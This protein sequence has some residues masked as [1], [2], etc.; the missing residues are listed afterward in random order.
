M[1]NIDYHPQIIIIIHKFYP[2]NFTELFFNYIFTQSFLT[3]PVTRLPTTSITTGAMRIL[4]METSRTTNKSFTIVKQKATRQNGVVYPPHF[5][6]SVHFLLTSQLPSVLNGLFEALLKSHFHN[7]KL[8]PFPNLILIFSDF[9]SL[10]LPKM[11]SSLS[12]PTLSPTIPRS[13]YVVQSTLPLAPSKPINLR[14]CGLRREALGFSSLNQSDSHR[15]RL[16]ASSR[17][18]KVSASLSDNGS[19]P[20]SFDYDLLIIG[21][22]V[23]GHGAALHAVEKVRTLTLIQILRRNCGSELGIQLNCNGLVA[24]LSLNAILVAQILCDFAK[25]YCI[26]QKWLISFCFCFCKLYIRSKALT[27]CQCA[28]MNCIS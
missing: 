17:S 12:L 3:V 7:N 28:C 13:N 11:Q 9:R 6:I 21:A 25:I 14:F 27:M 26:S 15:V 4:A 10:T 5:E 22:G 16:A 23:G 24:V 1:D 19:A 2:L 20:K 8:P 18:K